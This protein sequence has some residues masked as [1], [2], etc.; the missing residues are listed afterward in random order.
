MIKKITTLAMVGLF[1]LMANTV[2]AQW[3]AVNNGLPATTARGVGNVRDTLFTAIDGHGVYFSVNSGNNWTAWKN[4]SKLP[5]KE[6][7]K[8]F[9]VAATKTLADIGD[10]GEFLVLGKNMF[11]RYVSMGNGTV[12]QSAFVNYNVPTG[13]KVTAWLEEENPH[14]FHIGTT[15]GIYY[16][17]KPEESALNPATMTFTKA[18]GVS[19]MINNLTIYEHDDDSETIIASTDKGLYKS[20]DY[21]KT[22]TAFT[23]IAVT[24]EM[25]TYEHSMI[26][27]TSN[28][29]FFQQEENNVITYG[30]YI[31]T[32]DYRTIFADIDMSVGKMFMY[33]FGNNIATKLDFV[34]PAGNK[35]LSVQGITG[36]AITS[37]TIVGNYLFVSTDNGG[38]FRMALE[39]GLGVAGFS[40]A[41]EA[42]FSV[43]PNPSTGEFKITTEKTVNVQLL[44]LTG[45]LLK[46]YYVNES[47]DI[48]ENLTPG[49]YLLKDATNGGAKKLIVK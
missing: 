34:N 41:P 12:T 38:V 23:G 47:A 35:E 39:G 10:N 15:D 8:L 46:T 43:S 24:S 18:T 4:N 6:I 21:G 2:S 5:S 14:T 27:A 49:V 31:P 19:G 3:T 22:Y 44:D 42:Q 11:T 16:Y 25:K 1:A 36:G 9:R 13:V 29:I 45:K 26:L 48:K 20:R 30:P 32:G 17:H 7:S 33:C 40:Q 28:G 37:S